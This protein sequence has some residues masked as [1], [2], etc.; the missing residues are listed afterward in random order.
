LPVSDGSPGRERATI[1]FDNRKQGPMRGYSTLEVA[2]LLNLSPERV[3]S[4]VRAG[5]LSPARGPRKELRF[6][7][8]DLVLLRTARELLEARIP[9][10]RVRR[11]LR[12]LKRQLPPGR[13]LSGVSIAADGKRIVV[14]DGRTRWSPEDGQTLFDFDVGELH[15]KVAPLSERLALRGRQREA[16]DADGWYEL[17]CELEEVSPD[18]ALEAYRKALEQDSRH[19]EAHVNLGRLL[20]EA[21]EVAAA[22]PHYRAALE[23]D[24]NNAVAAFDLGVALEDLGR[25]EEALV[26]YE[27]AIGV[28]RNFADAHYNLARL[29][30]RMGK[31]G[32]A[33]RHLRLYR[34]LTR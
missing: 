21:G 28:D 2:K 5:F 22:L 7:F 15:R 20:H 3:R 32:A 11:A 9:A 16:L 24:P 31:A 18:D 25:D 12:E 13:P 27:R 14:R 19:P 6:T 23:A 33:L 29:Y 30:E 26:A 10:R 4:L 8:Q 1:E 17:G 34:D